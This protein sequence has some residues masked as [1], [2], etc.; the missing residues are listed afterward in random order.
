MFQRSYLVALCFAVIGMIL[1]TRA[2][3]DMRPL[4]IFLPFAFG[5]AVGVALGRARPTARISAQL[6]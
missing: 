4:Q 2:F 5:V 6:P 1:I 3:P